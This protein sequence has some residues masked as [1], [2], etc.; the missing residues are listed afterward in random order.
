MGSEREVADLD[1][2]LMRI[3]PWVDKDFPW[4]ASE[5]RAAFERAFC[6][7]MEQSKDWSDVNPRPADT[8]P[9]Q[10]QSPRG[11]ERK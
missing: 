9:G 3:T 2:D 7:L 8:V 1:R 4:L 5:Q 10:A 11:K 6:A